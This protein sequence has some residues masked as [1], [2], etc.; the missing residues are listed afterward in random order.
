MPISTVS[1]KLKIRN[2]I[3]LILALLGVIEFII[4]AGSGFQSIP[5]AFGGAMLLFIAATNFCTQCPLLS[6][7]T[8]FFRRKRTAIPTRKL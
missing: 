7:V 5:D 1:G 6:A 2:G 3:R 4:F 8:Q